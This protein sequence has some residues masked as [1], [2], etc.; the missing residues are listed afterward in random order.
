MIRIL[1]LLLVVQV[2]I[3]VALY[4]P[5]GGDAPGTTALVSDLTPADVERIGIRDADGA[6]AIV[7]RAGEGWS[8]ASGLP[9][10]PVKV[11]TLL[12][13][14]LTGDPGFAI[15]TSEGAAR[16]F[17]VADD[18]F[19]R[20]I[21]LT[22][23]AGERTLFLGT[24]P[25]FRKIHVRRD[26][27]E[28]VFMIELNSYDA[29]AQEGPWLDR[30]L[31]TVTDPTELG[32][33][34]VQLRLEGENWVRDD[35]SVV[36]GEAA[37]QLVQ[38]LANLRVS[39]LVEAGDTDAAAAGEALRIDIGEADPALRLTVLDNPDLERYY[40]RRSDYEALFNTSA[41]DAERLIDAARAVAGLEEPEQTDGASDDEGG[42]GEVTQID[43]STTD[44]GAASDSE[45]A[46]TGAP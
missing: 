35:G 24:S 4:W 25:S 17:Q 33:Y 37:D 32:L 22:G 9:A 11:D 28:R 45:D 6:E 16:R 3:V 13:G 26:G 14:L 39:S 19:E 34:G 30:S 43:M 29:P 15:A 21:V 5:A 18:S 20:R 23:P 8:L 27:D 31:L 1:T 12:A 40:L 7:T 38:A 41:Y 2:A 44:D 10:D 42:D 46:S 36:E